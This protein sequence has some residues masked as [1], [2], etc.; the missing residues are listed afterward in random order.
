[1]DLVDE[2][3]AARSPA[4]GLVRPVGN[5]RDAVNAQVSRSA[6]LFALQHYAALPASAGLDSQRRGVLQLAEDGEELERFAAIAGSLGY[7]PEFLELVDADRRAAL[8]G[9]RVGVRRGV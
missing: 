1:V 4:V 5:L 3:L 7:P 9:R 2:Q 6:L 8:A